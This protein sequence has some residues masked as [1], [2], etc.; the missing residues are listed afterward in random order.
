[1]AK[2]KRN[3]NNNTSAQP[4]KSATQ[5]KTNTVEVIYDKNTL[6]TLIAVNGKS[7]DT[8]RINGKEIAD[9]AYPFMMRKICW[10]GFYEE[11]VQALGGQ[12][13]FDLVFEGS[14][15]AL[16][17]LR[18]AWKDAPVNIIS[19]SSVGNVVTIT[20]NENNLKTA[21]TVNGQ[22]FDTSRINGKEIADWVYPFMMRKVK[23]DGIFE[24]LAK[25]VGSQEYAIRFSGSNV[26]MDELIEACPESV[27]IQKDKEHKTNSVTNNSNVLQEERI[28]D[29]LTRFAYYMV[30]STT[31]G[32]EDLD[33]LI[34]N[35]LSEE[36]TDIIMKLVEAGNPVVEFFASF[37]TEDDEP[38]IVML[39]K[40]AKK[41]FAPSEFLYA[42]FIISSED[43]DTDY[44]LIAEYLNE[45][46]NDPVIK[47]AFSDCVSDIEDVANELDKKER[48]EESF[49][50]RKA[51]EKYNNRI[52]ISNIGWHYHYGKGV[53]QDYVKAFEWYKKAAEQGDAWAQNKIGWL[54]QNGYGVIQDYAK[55]FEWYKKA[56][57][58]GNA[59]A[60]GNLG[61][62]YYNGY[63]VVQNYAK[64]FEWYKKAAEQGNAWAQNKLGW[65]YQ[66]GYGVTQDYAKAFEWYKKAAE[67]GNADAQGNVGFFYEQGY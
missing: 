8:S 53:K 13:A 6:E 52:S 3:R 65:L 29:I 54:Y 21:I 17:E 24:E 10:N 34:L 19:K 18:E 58:Q 43:Y 26:A 37:N 28:L 67:Q 7:F 40:S 27:S 62:F 63:G 32:N 20:Y 47:K 56:A 23:W 60:Q 12:K 42:I 22:P 57:E 38:D 25:A 11:M 55:A 15:E 59:D 31:A 5:A 30:E 50:L 64:A 14:E 9:W 48:Y 16:I 2:K 4:V 41:G 1:M 66:N 61:F 35:E 46:T 33:T 49:A 44:T 45:S 51:I 39:E 36:D